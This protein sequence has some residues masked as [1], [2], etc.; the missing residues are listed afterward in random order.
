M[1]PDDGH[2]S[3]KNNQKNRVCDHMGRLEPW[4]MLYKLT[5]SVLE[6]FIEHSEPR[7]SISTEIAN[8]VFFELSVIGQSRG[9]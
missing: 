4:K 8:H 6:C 2:A 7:K 5:G 3:D 1:N 9:R